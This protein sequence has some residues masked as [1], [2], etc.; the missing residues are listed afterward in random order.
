MQIR[1]VFMQFV[2]SHKLLYVCYVF[3][4]HGAS[5]VRKEIKETKLQIDFESLPENVWCQINE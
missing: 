2:R 5:P 3:T 4:Q 1:S